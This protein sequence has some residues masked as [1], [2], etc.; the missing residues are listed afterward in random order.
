M[1]FL[2]QISHWIYA[3]SILILILFENNKLHL[4][5]LLFIVSIQ[6]LSIV[7][8]R[9]CP[10]T[11]IER[12]YTRKNIMKIFQTL[13]IAYKC[14]HEYEMTLNTMIQVWLA[15]SFKLFALMLVSFFSNFNTSCSTVA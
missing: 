14:N 11:Q 1:L 10:L 15:I 5:I 8:F 4:C 12:K 3:L 9:G 7:V 6:T 2:Y 13:G